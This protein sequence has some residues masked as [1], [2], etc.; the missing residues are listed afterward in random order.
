MNTKELLFSRKSVRTF[1]G[2]AITEE[3]RSFIMAAAQA[4]PVAMGQYETYH[5]TVVTN[6]ELLAAIERAGGE[7]FGDPERKMLYGAP[8]LIIVS[9]HV[10]P[11]AENFTYSSAAIIVHNMALAAT[12][13]GVGSCD[14]WGCIGA[15]AKQSELTARLNLPEGYTP[16]CAVALGKT[17]ETFSVREIP[18]ERIATNTIE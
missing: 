10:V 2:E 11:G 15:A 4:A 12:E 17:E 8:T 13:L 5:L 7:L 6:K 14:I 3:E 1:T 16:C 9:A 18:E